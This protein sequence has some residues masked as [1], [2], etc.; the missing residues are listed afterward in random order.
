MWNR[1]RRPRTSRTA[2]AVALVLASVTIVVGP[3][4]RD[5]ARGQVTCRITSA[6]AFFYADTVR[7]D[8]VGFYAHVLMYTEEC[9]LSPAEVQA[10]FRPV[11][12]TPSTCN[13]KGTLQSEYAL[14]QGAQGIAAPGTPV[15][16]E[17]L[18]RTYGTAGADLFSSSCTLVVPS[19]PAGTAGTSGSRSSCPL[20]LE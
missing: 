10:T 7:A 13:F 16:V 9:G 18:G 5:E 14:C 1:G 11:S 2:V 4:S 15:V 12:G 19:L 20:P 6:D 17:A 3:V 8:V